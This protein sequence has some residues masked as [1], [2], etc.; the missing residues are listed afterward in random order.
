MLEWNVYFADINK[1]KILVFN[2]FNHQAFY[3]DL[4]YELNGINDKLDFE[5]ILERNCLYYFGAKCEY[6]IILT[7]CP[8]WDR[9]NKGKIDIYNQLQL[10]WN[11]FVNYVW[12]NRFDL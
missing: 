8:E 10:N 11:K 3:N 5:R 7:C 12:E 6:E 1:L 2:V 9:F 4:K